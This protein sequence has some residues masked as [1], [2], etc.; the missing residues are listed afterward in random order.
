VS[1]RRVAVV[2]PIK[3]FDSAKSRLREFLDDEVASDLA[4]DLARGVIEA[5][6]PRERLVVCEDDEVEELAGAL[7][8]EPVRSNATGLNDA[9]QE[10]Y[11][12][13]S[14]RFDVI[15]VAHADIA[16]PAGLGSFEPEDGVTI[17]TDRHRQ[18][19]NVLALPTGIGFRFAFGANSAA[20]HD[21]EAMRLGV[22]RRVV[23]D[24]P[25][26]LDV[27]GPEDLAEART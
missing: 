9:V 6:A 27:D 1:Q 7:G 14:D 3:A 16:R 10:A 5:S 23:T 21:A 2:I 25:W 20:R 4:R 13:L 22:A 19:T 11:Q 24:S 18:G 15:I 17:V 12:R 26:G 8:A